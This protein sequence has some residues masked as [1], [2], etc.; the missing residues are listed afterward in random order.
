[1][2]IYFC[3]YFVYLFVNN[4]ISSKK[5]PGSH[6]Q[7]PFLAFLIGIYL[8]CFVISFLSYAI[9]TLHF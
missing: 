6:G 2:F 4:T 9:S 5:T 8:V 7:M 1:M 3:A